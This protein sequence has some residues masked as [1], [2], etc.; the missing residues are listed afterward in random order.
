MIALNTILGGINTSQTLLDK[1]LSKK[2]TKREKKILAVSL[3]QKAINNTEQYLVESQS[4]Y[5][6]NQELSQLWLDAFTAMV[7]IDK[8]LAKSL[9][10]KSRFWSNPE[11]WLQNVGS[12]ELIP[13]LRDLNEKCEMLIETLYFRIKKNE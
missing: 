4:N 3:L 13:K 12:M 5:R 9:R 11:L 8:E 10:Q 7:S 6:P 2:G 1:V